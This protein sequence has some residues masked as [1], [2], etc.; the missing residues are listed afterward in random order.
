MP[1]DDANLQHSKTDINSI[2][3]AVEDLAKESTL[4]ALKEPALK[5]EQ[6]CT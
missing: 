5:E 2:V 4:K 3:S 1:I 6:Y